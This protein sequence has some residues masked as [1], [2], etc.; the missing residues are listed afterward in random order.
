MSADVWDLNA[1]H[2]G[3]AFIQW[4]GTSVCMDLR[5]TVCRHHNHYDGDFCY[6]AQCAKCK[7]VFEMNCF[8]QFWPAVDLNSYG[9]QHPKQSEDD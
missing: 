3:M 1:P 4:K 6:Y 7:T 5:C 9:A 2:P 8:V